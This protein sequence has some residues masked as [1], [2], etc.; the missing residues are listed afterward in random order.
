MLSLGSGVVKSAKPSFVSYVTPEEIKSEKEPSRKENL[1]VLLPGEVMFCSA[2][3]VLRYTQ[4]DLSQRGVFGTLVCTNFRV[5]FVS[6][7]PSVEKAQL[8][9]NKLYGENDIPLSCVDSIYGEK[10]R[11][12]RVV[13]APVSPG[14]EDK[15]KLMTGSLVKNKCPSKMII[16]C[17]DLRVFHFTLT[18]CKEDDSKRIFQGIIHHCL[19]PKSLKCVFAFSY[20][21]KTSC[22]EKQRKERTLQFDSVED[23]AQD[24][25]RVKG[26][27]RLVTENASFE[28]SPELPQVFIVP[29]DVSDEDL[30]AFQGRGIPMWCWSHHSGCAL[31]KTSTLPVLPDDTL[32]QAYM[33]RMLTAVAA[34]YLYSV[35]TE[36]LSDTLPSL[37]DVQQSYNKFKHFFLI[38][39]TT[40]FWVS[41]VKW[42]SS[43]ENCGWLDII[44]QCLQKSVEVVECLEKENS[45]VLIMEEGGSDLCCVVS[46]LVQ[47]MLDPFYRT[48]TGFQSLVQ[49]EWVA[50]GHKFLDRCNLLQLKDKENQ[51]PVFLLF[52]ECVWQLLHQ[53][54]QAFQF[55]ETYLTVLSDSTHVPLFSTFLFNSHHHRATFLRCWQAELPQAQRGP[56]NCPPVWDWS[57]QFD[58]KAQDLFINPLYTDKSRQDRAARKTHRP[59]HQRQLSLPGCAFKTPPKKGF[60]R[61]ETDSLKKILRVR[62]VSRWMLSPDSPQPPS[63]LREFYACWL[64]RPLDPHGLLLPC[65]TGPSVRVWMQRYL[66]W[67]HEVQIFGGGPV[68]VLSKVADLL[69]EVQDLQRELQHRSCSTASDHRNNSTASD[70]RNNSTA[71][72]HRNNSTD[73][74]GARGR[75]LGEAGSM[76]AKN[77]VRLSSSYPF[78][79]HRN[80]SFKPAIP[81]SLLQGLLVPGPLAEQDDE[82]E[83]LV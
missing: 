50:G 5:S 27:C 82:P 37:Q 1:P 7:E 38:D 44:R 26:T 83:T 81:S 24:M 40:E 42:F 23:W 29:S 55:S 45:N 41:D 79:T 31:F 67:I 19:E 35:K 66:R 46:S 8:F 71:S 2:S 6:D 76:A 68:T 3:T 52:L 10:K 60:F 17:K 65:L 78:V 80:W 72:D 28:L 61:D 21:E 70:H 4:D 63:S 39:N 43:L 54:S 59:K 57:V 11:K 75:V 51:A 18:F 48:L 62:R 32:S 47:L 58:C 15:K 16:H 77:A 56:L 25:R 69:S 49:K 34:N 9:K 14:Y 22:P 36:D 30:T 33:E 53:Y 64:R 12:S 13:T 73:H 74:G 20:C